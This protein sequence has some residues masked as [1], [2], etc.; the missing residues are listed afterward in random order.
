[1]TLIVNDPRPFKLLLAG[2]IFAYLSADR[3]GARSLIFTVLLQ[4]AFA[5]AG[6]DVFRFAAVPNA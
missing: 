2:L 4:G 5:V 3:S 6:R 1:N